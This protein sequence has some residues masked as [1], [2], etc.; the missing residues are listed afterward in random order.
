M[1]IAVFGSQLDRTRPAQMFRAE[2]ASLAGEAP[3]AT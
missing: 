1:I 2:N 3:A